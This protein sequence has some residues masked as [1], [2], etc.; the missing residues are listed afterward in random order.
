MELSI[1]VLT[2]R[3]TSSLLRRCLESLAGEAGAGSG[4]EVLVGLNGLGD[5]AAA[6]RAALSREFP[7]A[8]TVELPALARGE[9]RNRLVEL[10]AAPIVHFLDDDAWV[11][12]GFARRLLDVYARHPE[13]PAVGGPNVGPAGAPAFERA[14]D[15]L[16]RSPLGAGPMR[17]RYRRAGPE[18]PRPGWSFML[19]NLGARK[20]AFL[21]CTGFP[22]TASAE[23]NLLLYRVERRFG[24]AVFSPELSVF[25]R[26][27]AGLR[28]F[29]SQVW[30]N[31]KGRGQITAAEPGSLQA[32]V[33]A[34]LAL[35]LLPAAALLRPAAAAGAFCAY[36][37]ACLLEGLRM[38]ALERDLAG[39]ALVAPLFLAAHLAY[40]GGCAAGLCSEAQHAV[41]APKRVR[42]VASADL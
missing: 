4:V 2:H 33:L 1:V 14:V 38:A 39:A 24:R 37:G 30:C 41:R 16:L 18:G 17:A 13:A 5:Q 20:K 21:A 40:A 7:W 3:G 42:D 19:T 28:A 26:R 23:E 34:P 6:E 32:A 22:G 29:L 8:R 15:F 10:C 11:P 12:A 36:A 35:A 25:H 31:G 27:R 9:A